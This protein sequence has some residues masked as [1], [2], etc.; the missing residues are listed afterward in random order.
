MLWIWQEKMKWICA[1]T[2]VGPLPQWPGP[3]QVAEKTLRWR[4]F[5]IQCVIKLKMQNYKNKFV[6]LKGRGFKYQFLWQMIWW[7][8][9]GSRII[10]SCKC[11]IL[12]ASTGMLLFLIHRFLV[13]IPQWYLRLVSTAISSGRFPQQIFFFFCIADCI[14]LKDEIG[15]SHK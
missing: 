2:S 14:I 8:Y 1:I 10:L 6:P 11:R 4:Y 3:E 15:P 12:L 7:L 9:W 13:W 5:F